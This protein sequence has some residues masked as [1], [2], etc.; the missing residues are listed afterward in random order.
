MLHIHHFFIAHDEGG[1]IPPLF[2]V[3]HLALEEARAGVDEFS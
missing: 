2:C 3:V 1:I